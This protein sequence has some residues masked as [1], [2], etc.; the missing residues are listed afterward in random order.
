MIPSNYQLNKL[1]VFNR[2]LLDLDKS[3][4]YQQQFYELRNEVDRAVA[5]INSL[6]AQQRFDEL[7]TYRSNMQGVLNVKGQVRAIERYLDNW[8]KRR[9]RIL[10]DE[11]LSITVKSDLIR[12]LELER[13]MRLAMVPELRKQANIPVF[14]L[15]L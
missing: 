10:Q 8:R 15:N 3:G 5:T 11:N 9:D 4:G 2:L 7:A 14:S 1:P 13:D 12:E 6:Q